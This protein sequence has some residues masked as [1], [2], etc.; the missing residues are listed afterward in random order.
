MATL[1]QDGDVMDYTPN[2]DITAGDIEVVG[3]LVGVAKT[4]IGSGDLG[5]LA[6]GGIYELADAD[7]DG[8]ATDYSQGDQVFLSTG[9]YFGVAVADGSGTTVEARLQQTRGSDT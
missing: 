7:V 4:D 2:A 6:L 5:S 8:S 9:E 1:I 3:E